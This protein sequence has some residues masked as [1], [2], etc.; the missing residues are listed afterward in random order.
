[1][2]DSL[3]SLDEYVAIVKRRKWSL[4]LPMLVVMVSAAAVAFLLPSVYKS[5]A[6]ILIEEQ[7]IP[8]DFVKATVTSYA[9]QRIQTINQWI[10]SS[11]RLVEVINRFELYRD[12]R[13]TRTTEEL[14]AQMRNDTHLEMINAEV[15]DPRNGRPSEAAIAFTLSFEG[16]G[17][18]QKI[19]Q[20]AN[21]LTSLFLEKNLRVRA[22]QTKETSQFL[23]SEMNKVKE[24]LDLLDGRIAAFKEKNI[25]TLPELLQVNTQML[26]TIERNIETLQ[27]QLRS[28]KEREGYL[29]AQLANMSPRLEDQQ[30]DKQH[31]D[32]LK[33]KLVE[34]KSRFTDSYPDVIKT[35]A[36]IADLERQ[37]AANKADP[38]TARQVPDNPAYVTL[39]AQ[40]SSSRSE[41]NSIQE[42]IHKLE[43]K[44]EKYQR[45]IART[46]KVEEAYRTLVAERNNTQAKYDD[47]MRKVMEARVSQGLEKEQKGERFTLIDPARLP[48]KPFKP[49]R[50]A[51]ILIG[52]VV[53]IGTGVGTAALREF[54]DTSVHSAGR[55]SQL[56]NFPVLAVVPV[57]ATDGDL[58]RRRMKKMAVTVAAVVLL[59]GGLAVFHFQI[60][61]LGVLWLKVKG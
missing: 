40:L 27:S 53:G 60:M 18:P 52:V 58:A 25:N 8:A 38:Q 29:Q 50:L 49:N 22:Q 31:L 21:E 59:V 24:T 35:R 51:I 20:V 3:M 15:V 61:D 32:M 47:L 28:E 30:E 13:D 46:P 54:S 10:M 1:M 23:E 12:M 56:T 5:T 14:V 26:S 7:E 4:F 41:I 11:T 43:V 37:M 33:I 57:I 2:D 6:T 55:L 45:Q 19:Q 44:G 9:Q 17:A 34:L 36:E 16:K 42:Q 39:T 48:E